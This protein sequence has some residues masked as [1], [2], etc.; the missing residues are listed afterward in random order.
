MTQDKKDR[1]T[2]EIWAVKAV[3][4]RRTHQFTPPTDVI[5]LPDRLVI[6]IEIPGMRADDFQITLF[7]RSLIISGF[8][9]RP[10]FENPA[11]HQVEISF[12]E[13]RIEIALPGPVQQAQVSATYREGFLQ[14]DLP[15]L[16]PS[17]VEISG[18]IDPEG[19][20]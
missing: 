14:I 5:E 16:L 19:Q 20:D 4:T 15:R 6:L 11:Y 1:I 9:E 7:N 8:R 12:G 3:M 17:Q 13:F 18:G 2:E 10:P